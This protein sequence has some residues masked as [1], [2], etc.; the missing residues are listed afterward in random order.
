[1][2]VSTS[3]MFDSGTATILQ[4]QEALIKTQ[5]QLSTGRRILTPADD[6][7]AAAQAINLSQAASINTQYSTNR[8]HA[9]TS[10]GLVETALDNV[11]TNL[12]DIRQIAV[13][14]GNTFLTDSDRKI[15]A[16]ELR[17]RFEALLGQA[18]TTDGTG[19]Y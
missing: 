3:G 7:I 6:P 19:N 1:M 17:S 14:A 9:I 18:N 15:L 11:S 12:Q 10:L 13:Q 5:Q 16:V 4:M 8:G 2:R